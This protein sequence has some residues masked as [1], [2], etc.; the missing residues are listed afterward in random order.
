MLKVTHK[1]AITHTQLMWSLRTVSPFIDA[2]LQSAWFIDYNLGIHNSLF[3]SWLTHYS[4]QFYNLASML[5]PLSQLF[6]QMSLYIPTHWLPIGFF[7]FLFAF[8]DLYL[9]VQLPLS[10]AYHF[11]FPSTLFHFA[12]SHLHYFLYLPICKLT[13]MLFCAHCSS[14]QGCVASARFSL[15]HLHFSTLISKL[16][17]TKMSCYSNMLCLHAFT[18]QC[19]FCTTSSHTFFLT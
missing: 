17:A 1:R 8:S 3:G 4:T 7:G 12:L 5:I 2:N 18:W 10:C 14:S 13:L 15:H 9:I 6:I 11:I 19:H 16:C